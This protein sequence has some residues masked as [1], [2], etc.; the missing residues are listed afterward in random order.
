MT[1]SHTLRG[2][3]AGLLLAVV[4]ADAR[5]QD[6]EAAR[7]DSI[8]GEQTRPDEA[9]EFPVSRAAAPGEKVARW[10]A[11]LDSDRYEVRERASRELL[12]NGHTA[13]EQLAETA[14]G[15]SPEAAARAIAVLEELSTQEQDPELQVDVLERLAALENRASVSRRATERL[16]SVW[17][18]ISLPIVLE[19]GGRLDPD[20]AYL[21]PSSGQQRFGKLILGPEWTGG[22]E[23]LVHVGRLT[24]V[25]AVSIRNA[26]VT[27]EGL[28]HL[29]D[30]PSLQILELYGVGLDEGDQQSLRGQFPYVTLDIR[31]GAMLGVR[32]SRQ[33]V[34]AEV[35]SVEPDSAAQE[36]GL[37]AGDV[38]TKVDD[39]EVKSFDELT[40]E[41]AKF[42]P[43]EETVLQVRRGGKLIERTVVFGQWE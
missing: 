24:F 14:D 8:A 13:I 6:D 15:P 39:I 37:Q 30:M 1:L 34:A 22:D 27:P 29:S 12:E 33:S 23:G 41:I 3:V 20:S 43:G 16:A 35:H 38:I 11:D 19:L 18:R 10:I 2:I 25:Y 26:A 17:E 40:T 32:G 36:A 42:N 5:G 28:A 9:G 21:D 4:G 7:V 31:R